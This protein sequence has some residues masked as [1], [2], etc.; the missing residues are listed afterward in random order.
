MVNKFL[1]HLFLDVMFWNVWDI[2]LYDRV[3]SSRIE[4]Y[5]VCKKFRAHR[6]CEPRHDW[7]EATTEGKLTEK[8]SKGTLLRALRDWASTVQLCWIVFAGLDTCKNWKDFLLL[9][10][11]GACGLSLVWFSYFARASEERRLGTAWNFPELLE[12]L[13]F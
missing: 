1:Q 7:V 5:R 4:S 12:F 2:I 11:K 8:V 6:D 3:V 10:N 9:R 13:L